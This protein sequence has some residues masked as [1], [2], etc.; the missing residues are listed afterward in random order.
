M[1]ELDTWDAMQL[2]FEY[3]KKDSI[4]ILELNQWCDNYQKKHC[5]TYVNMCRD[6]IGY[7][8]QCKNIWWEIKDFE[9]DILHKQISI[10]YPLSGFRIYK[11]PNTEKF[12]KIKKILEVIKIDVT[13][14]LNNVDLDNDQ[15]QIRKN[16]INNIK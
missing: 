15:K 5:N 12:E 4:T 1:E 8:H 9:S 3:Y 7:E 13:H 14:I 16:I 2:A 11:Y 6:D 10:L